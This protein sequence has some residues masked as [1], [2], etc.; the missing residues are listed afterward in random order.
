[1]ERTVI[2]LIGSLRLDNCRL[3][4]VT[5]RY[6]INYCHALTWLIGRVI[7]FI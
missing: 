6:V 2:T 5:C 3:I 4:Q 1:M 7:I